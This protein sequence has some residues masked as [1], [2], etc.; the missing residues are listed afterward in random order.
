MAGL[1]AHGFCREPPFSK[2]LSYSAGGL[3]ILTLSQQA[4]GHRCRPLDGAQTALLGEAGKVTIEASLNVL[5]FIKFQNEAI[6][7]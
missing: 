6:M 2:K 4:L 3:S 5:N 7:I 1:H